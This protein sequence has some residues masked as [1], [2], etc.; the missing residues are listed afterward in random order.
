MAD[1]AIVSST[2]IAPRRLDKQF[3]SIKHIIST[4]K[5]NQ[6][7][8]FVVAGIIVLSCLVLFALSLSIMIYLT[9]GLMKKRSHMC[10]ELIRESDISKHALPFGYAVEVTTISALLNP[11]SGKPKAKSGMLS[12]KAFIA[13]LATINNNYQIYKGSL[14]PI[15][16]W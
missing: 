7:D 16:V 13:V 6:G 1:A 11:R 3:E 9:S 12:R 15:L 8:K 10:G 2:T 5:N 4:S 14:G